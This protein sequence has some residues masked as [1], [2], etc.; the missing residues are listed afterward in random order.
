MRRFQTPPAFILAQY[1]MALVMIGAATGALFLVRFNL[2]TA[3]IALLYLLPVGLA[4]ALWGLGP[5]I[6]AALGA[7]L[8]FNYFF[9][10]PTF[11]FAVH[12]PQDLLA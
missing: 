10:P 3:T 9:L 6:A 7:F 1:V 12:Q 4:T 5:A 11:T 2:N 8:A